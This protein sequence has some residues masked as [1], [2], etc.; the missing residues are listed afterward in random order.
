MIK[1]IIIVVILIIFAVL[2]YLGDKA[3]KELASQMSFKEAMDLTDLPV[4]TFY[5][6]DK[7]INFLL[8][9]G[10]NDSL[11][12]G[13][14]VKKLELAYEKTQSISEVYGIGGKTV[15]SH[16]NINFEYKN[17]KFKYN[18]QVA[19]LTPTFDVIKQETG[20]VIHGIL[21]SCFFK[22]FK[23]ILDFDKF[24]AYSKK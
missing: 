21:G 1:V 3:D 5:Q 16:V 11:I 15:V 14:A 18:F 13:D 6:G 4:V 20:V 24:V 8:D 19:N 22:E 7:K 12:N 17:I 23:Y 10:S 9:T 2:F